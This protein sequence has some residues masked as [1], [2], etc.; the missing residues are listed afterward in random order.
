MANVSIAE[1]VCVR[2]RREVRNMKCEILLKSGY[3]LLFKGE[4]VVLW[5]IHVITDSI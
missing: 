3:T 2:A 4:R 1:C 5:F